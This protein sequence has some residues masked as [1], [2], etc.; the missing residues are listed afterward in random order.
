VA[1]AVTH[2]RDRSQRSRA[3]RRQHNPARP[4]RCAITSPEEPVRAAAGRIAAR[5]AVGGNVVREAHRVGQHRGLVDERPAFERITDA[6]PEL[7]SANRRAEPFDGE[8]ARVE[9][10]SSSR[11]PRG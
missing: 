11:P 8:R 3:R 10:R 1:G 7:V 9:V 4:R 5:S 6:P 2:H